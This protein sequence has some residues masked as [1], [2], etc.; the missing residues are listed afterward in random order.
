MLSI[1]KKLINFIKKITFKHTILGKPNFQYNLEPE[2]LS[3]III[4]LK[5][6]KNING[7]ICEIGVGIIFHTFLSN[8]L[9]PSHLNV[10]IT[11]SLPI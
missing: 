9:V 3:E 1:K 8:F 4:S 7:C 2:Q 10:F 6:V 11:F 5:K